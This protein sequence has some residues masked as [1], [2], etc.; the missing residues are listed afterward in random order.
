MRTSG[1]ITRASFDAAPLPQSAGCP[2][3]TAVTGNVTLIP[4]AALVAGDAK[5]LT[6]DQC[7]E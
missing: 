7:T 5:D 4:A 2:H 6:T 3:T 1:C